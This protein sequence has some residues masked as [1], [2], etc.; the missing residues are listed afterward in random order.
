MSKL[1]PLYIHTYYYVTIVK[2]YVMPRTRF[3]V[4]SKPAKLISTQRGG[5]QKGFFKSFRVP[6]QTVTKKSN[7]HGLSI[8]YVHTDTNKKWNTQKVN[9]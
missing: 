8:T 7:R 1:Q 5:G 2:T 4:T 6:S 9:Q 3:R